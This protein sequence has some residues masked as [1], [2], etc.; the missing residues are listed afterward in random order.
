[1]TN[2]QQEVTAYTKGLGR[3]SLSFHGY[4]VCHNPQEVIA[5]KGYEPERDLE[6]P[7]SS[8]FCSHGAGFFVPWD[9]VWEYAHLER[10]W[11]KEEKQEVEAAFI[12]PKGEDEWLGTEEIDEIIEKT[13]YANRGERTVWKKRK[14]IR[15]SQPERVRTYRPQEVREPYLL[16]DGYNIIFAWE[17]LCDL[18]KEN[19]DGARGRLLDY[20]A[21]YQGAKGCQVMVVFDAYRVEGHPTEVL[22]YHN[23]YVVYTKEA[24]TADQ[25]IEKFAHEN[26][27]KYA[28]TVATSDGLEQVIIRGQGCQLLSANELLEE[29]KDCQRLLRE[30]YIDKPKTGRSFLL[31]GVSEKTKEELA[32]LGRE[33]ERENGANQS[34]TTK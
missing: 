23:I 30:T 24:E 9:E 3:L 27:K 29:L 17:E 15:D 28:I 2:Y 34:R 4:E 6:N 12:H 20:M 18:A 22:K 5:L 21:N 8:V 25:Y 13:F 1:M 7:S 19:M 16:V 10:V 26:A 14:K 32:F 33:K 11:K 31:E